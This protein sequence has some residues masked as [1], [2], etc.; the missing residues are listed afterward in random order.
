M[1]A[2]FPEILPDELLY[3]AIARYRDMM[4]FP[5]EHTVLRT[6]FGRK[7]GIAVVGLPGR[8]EALVQNFPPGHGY[9]VDQLIQH[10][11]TLPYYL[12]YVA[13]QQART[14]M[15]R[16]RQAGSSGIAELLGI[17]ASTVDQPAVLRLCRQCA[18]ADA[19]EYGAPY[20]RRTH[21]MPGVLLCP[22][23]QTPLHD[24]PIRRSQGR[25]RHTFRSLAAWSRDASQPILPRG[26][27]A[28]LIR[29]ATDTAWLLENE[30]SLYHLAT[31]RACYWSHLERL[32]WLRSE[33]QI[34]ISDLRAAFVAH[35]SASF[36]DQIGCGLQTR[37]GEDDWLAR[38][39][40]KP[41]AAHHPLRH[42][43]VTHFLGL[44]VN[45]FFEDAEAHLTRVNEKATRTLCPNP[46]CSRQ[47]RGR[48]TCRPA[49]PGVL[50]CSACGFTYKPATGPQSRRRVIVYG[51]AWEA[52]LRRLVTTTDVSL[53]QIARLLDAD[54]KTIQREAEGLGVWREGWTHPPVTASRHNPTQ[55]ACASTALHRATWLRLRREYPHEG[56][57]ALRSRAP[58]TYTHLYRY[59]SGWLDA[60]RP[61]RPK[62]I[63][64]APRVDWT[65][66]DAEVLRSTQAAVKNIVETSERPVR[67]LRTTIARRIG[68]VSLLEQHLSRL[69]RTAVF[70]AAATESSIDYGLRKLRWA[71]ER[72]AKEG[73]QPADWELTRRAALRPEQIP[74][75]DLL[76]I[77]PP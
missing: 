52:E 53:R 23:H 72:F 27:L 28:T 54:P 38:L 7:A 45:E 41:R 71:A 5:N 30:P 44:S 35:Y 63:P 65:A 66:R 25:G 69:P 61:A 40:R 26:N 51:S 4:D 31:L 20:W 58:A 24:S 36:L 64:R 48:S 68:H 29:L 2:I 1:S 75:R 59:D 21:Q 62:P 32:G 9:T 74:A 43:L 18:D 17:R 8:L 46:A 13:P 33:R 14:A 22:Q 12:R 77:S 39:L 16:L 47:Q 6:L 19:R 34:R 70:L 57:Q 49:S 76:V 10:H 67:I 55:R 11:T 3:S 60:N 73:R 50:Q 42:L 15:Q 37:T 56:T